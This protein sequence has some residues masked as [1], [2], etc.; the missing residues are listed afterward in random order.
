[1]PRTLRAHWIAAGL[2]VLCA[3]ATLQQIAALRRV[4][5]AL[6]GVRNGRIAGVALSRIAAY[7]D[8]TALD[9]GRIA[10]AVASNNV[11]LEFQLDVR[12][13]NPAENRTT[14]TM[15]RLAWTLLLDNR[16]TING[17]LD[18]SLTLPAGQT[19]VIPLQMRLNLRQFF[20]GPIES[21]VDLAAG[22]AGVRA[23]PTRVS[24]K[25]TPTINTPIGPIS[26][27]SPITI[28]SGTIGASNS[29]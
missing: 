16:E 24:I 5:F 14:A 23:D 26:Y 12:A 9:V 10:L 1:M 8:L 28:V 4:A 3:C 21:L 2:L 25:A 27:P 6:G 20:S 22:V 19:V 17:S 29:P 15:V 11:P 13:Q 7:R 18:S